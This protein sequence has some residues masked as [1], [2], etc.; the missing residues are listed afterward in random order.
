M[1]NLSTV[2]S[3]YTVGKETEW[4]RKPLQAHPLEEIEPAL[5]GAD[6]VEKRRGKGSGK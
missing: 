4:G 6:G 1:R 3:L 5:S 2:T